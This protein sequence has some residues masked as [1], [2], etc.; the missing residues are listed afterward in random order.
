M[1]IV[2]NPKLRKGIK[3]SY[4]KKLESN[5]YV[6]PRNKIIVFNLIIFLLI[7]VSTE[8]VTGKNFLQCAMR[9]DE[10]FR[11]VF[12]LKRGSVEKLLNSFHK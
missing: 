9:I 1:F 6:N 12:P 8:K 3:E 11:S 7:D 4:K 5:I 10:F 2:F